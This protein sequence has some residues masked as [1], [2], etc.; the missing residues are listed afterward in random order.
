VVRLRSTVALLVATSLSGGLAA[1]S[2]GSNTSPNSGGTCSGPGGRAR[3]PR[4]SL[5]NGGH[6][7][8]GSMPRPTGGIRRPSQWSAGG[9]NVGAAIFDPLSVEGADHQAHPCLARSLTPDATSMHWTI[10]P[11]PNISLRDGEPFNAVAI[12]LQL[13]EDRQ[14]VLGSQAFGSTVKPVDDLTVKVD[15]AHGRQ[16]SE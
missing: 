12:V 13:T 14:A 1:C 10:T 9:N 11:R 16:P 4:S 3:P 15:A 6:A 7:Q 2:S 8:S 5:A